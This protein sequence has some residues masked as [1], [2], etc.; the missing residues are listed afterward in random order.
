MC[1]LRR[2]ALA[3][4]KLG[5]LRV[6]GGHELGHPTM[7]MRILIDCVEQRYEAVCDLSL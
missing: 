5:P 1:Y 4:L 3:L 2:S 7:P 6:S